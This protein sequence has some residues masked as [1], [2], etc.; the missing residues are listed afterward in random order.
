VCGAPS[1]MIAEIIAVGSELVTSPRIDTNSLFLTARLNELGIEVRRK[2][3]VADN[4]DL[5]AAAIR[6]AHQRAHVV[7]LTGG[8]GPTEDDLT[9]EA[10]AAAFGLSLERDAGAESRLRQWFAGRGVPMAASNLKQADRIAGAELL[11]NRKGTAAGQ[12]LQVDG[13]IVVLLPGPPREI[14][15]MI[16]EQVVPRLRALAPPRHLVTR[17]L[18]IADRPESAVDE[19]AAPIY[20]RHANIATT[21]LAGAGDIEFRFR[22]TAETESEAERCA[23]AVAEEVAGAMGDAVYSRASEDLEA[24]VGRMLADRG[25][26]LATAESCTGGLVAERITAVPGA[27]R[28]FLGGVVSYSDELKMRLLD[29]SADA[30]RIHGAVSEPVAREMAD[31]A[32]RRSG[33]TWAVSITGIAGPDGGTA[34]KPVGLVFIGLANPKATAVARRAFFGDRE[35]IRRLAAQVALDGL[36]LALGNTPPFSPSDPR[37]AT[38]RANEPAPGLASPGA[39]SESGI[40]RVAP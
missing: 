5:L 11:P 33:A 7:A 21:I 39:G 6:E 17:V 37:P 28:Y 29:V 15:V 30:L 4:L 32:R 23:S 22:C 27:S 18:K 34:E 9:R 14:E 35:R 3:V 13:R 2:S 12:W 40:E 36:R 16:L 8:L 31:G 1:P 26:T 24:V 19:I 10:V 25:E 20:S 38:T